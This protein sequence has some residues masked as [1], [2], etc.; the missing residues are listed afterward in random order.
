MALCTD[1][2]GRGGPPSFDSLI[3]P[4]SSADFF[5]TS[6]EK[7]VITSGAV[8]GVCE[9][10]S[11]VEIEELISS[12]GTVSPDWIQVV[13]Q[14]ASLPSSA[15]SDREG[16]VSLP[17][18]YDALRAGH[19]LQ[20]SKLHRRHPRTARLCRSVEMAFLQFDVPFAGPI[21][22]HLYF[23]PPRSVG[24]W[25][26]YDDHNVFVLQVHGRKLWK[27]YG[28]REEHPVG[29]AE[30]RISRDELPPP[31]SEIVL[32][33]G[34]VLYVPRGVYHEAVAEDVASVHLTLD[35]YALTWLDILTR[36]LATRP[37]LR[38]ALPPGA[39]NADG[40]SAD[41]DRRFRAELDATELNHTLHDMRR[42]LLG[43]LSPLPASGLGQLS[44]L[45]RV[46]EQTVVRQRPGTVAA[47]LRNNSTL[48]LIFAGSGICGPPAAVEVFTFLADQR[49][50]S[51]KDIPG[52]LERD[53]KIEIVRELI[54][55]G[56]LEIVPDVERA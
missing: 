16:Y 40:T 52:G 5:R 45:D 4:L 13:R 38:E 21:G 54:V 44:D 26:H 48:H 23:T 9:L 33:A 49:Q 24:L 28:V 35:V 36:F 1:G 12:L 11:F 30:T 25:P 22:S 41:L 31:E 15:F 47:L 3:A 6:W 27:L 55:E 14:G 32:E 46:S 56:M 53:S 18:L 7:Q 8:P 51:V 42:D 37:T 19:T 2:E 20:L 34:R 10:M 17:S 50:F 39:L 43:S 29:R